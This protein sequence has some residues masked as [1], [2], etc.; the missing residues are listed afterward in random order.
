MSRILKTSSLAAAVFIGLSAGASSA[1]DRV[2]AKIPFSFVVRSEQFPAGRYEFTTS[3]GLLAIRGRDNDR[4]MFVITNPADGR[5]PIGDEP[6]LVF[7][8]Y[9]NTYRL[10]D[11]WNSETRGSSLLSHRDRRS[12]NRATSNTDPIVISLAGNAG[13]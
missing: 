12:A 7:S 2:D 11:I 3:Q 6:V 4:G 8:R 10:T 13:K 5:D 1:Q 9:E